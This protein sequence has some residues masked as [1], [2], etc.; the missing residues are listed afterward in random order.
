MSTSSSEIWKKSPLSL[1]PRCCMQ[2]EPRLWKP[3]PEDQSITLEPPQAWKENQPI[4]TDQGPMEV[5]HA[6][7]DK[8][9]LQQD[10]AQLVGTQVK[11]D[12]YIGQINNMFQAFQD[13]WV[14]RWDRHL[15][16]QESYWQPLVEFVQ[17]AFPHSP[18]HGVPKNQP[19]TVESSLA[20][21]KAPISSREQMV[22]QGRTLS[23]CPRH[24][25]LSS[26][27]SST[28]LKK[29]TNGHHNYSR[30]GW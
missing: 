30:D 23:T 8:L 3:I 7:P 16:V 6:E 26:L 19:G 9:W 29:G 12:E 1:A 10:P 5:I 25:N 17:L 20:P 15:H 2:Q 28:P 11:Q 21:Q 22:Y 4:W 18:G 13:E 27:I 24:W 14:K